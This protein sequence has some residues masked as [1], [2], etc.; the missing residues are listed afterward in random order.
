M[1]TDWS[2]RGRGI[3]DKGGIRAEFHHVIDIALTI[4]EAWSAI[5]VRAQ[6]R[7]AEAIEGVSMAYTFG[8]RSAVAA[9]YAVL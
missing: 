8:T 1:A 2:F 4:L 5:A 7:A 9:S 3:K 6:R